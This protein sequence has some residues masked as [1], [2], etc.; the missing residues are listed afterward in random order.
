MLGSHRPR[1]RLSQS[2]RV[3]GANRSP[4]LPHRAGPGLTVSSSS[5]GAG[6]LGT[7]GLRARGERFRYHVFLH[8][9]PFSA[10]E[11]RTPNCAASAGEHSPRR[12]ARHVIRRSRCERWR[13]W[14]CA[15]A[16]CRRA[17]RSGKSE[18]R[19]IRLHRPSACP[20]LLRD[21]PGRRSMAWAAGSL[22][23]C[24]ANE[25]AASCSLILARAPFGQCSA[26][27]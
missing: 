26:I 21:D 9:L 20:R 27:P 19:E 6:S 12:V 24:R 5:S 3:I 22:S 15:R 13:R 18:Q 7:Q 14:S 1:Q 11:T 17:G 2:R 23:R 4:R 8:V 25:V 16:H 10:R